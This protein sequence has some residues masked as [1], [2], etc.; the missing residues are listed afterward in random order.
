MVIKCLIQLLVLFSLAPTLAAATPETIFTQAREAYDKGDYPQAVS[1]YQSLV[2]QGTP[3]G[4]L[5]YNLGNSYYRTQAWG[6]AKA[7]Y[8]AARGLLPRNPDIKANLTLVHQKGGD[9]L[10]LTR[11]PSPFFFW[12]NW[13]TASEIAW[14]AA[15]LA[16]LSFLLCS[17]GTCVSR[18]KAVKKIGQGGLLLASLFAAATWKQAQ[19]REIWGAVVSKEAAVHS[20]PGAHNLSLFTLHEGAPLIWLQ[21]NGEW[22]QILLVEDK[23][24]RKGWVDASAIRVYP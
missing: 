1:L 7:A 6:E 3:S 4:Y 23:E 21:T 8:L 5:Y 24:E 2:K 14:I 18:L 16:G 13:A 19:S 22:A 12:K 15:L 10:Q 17:L 20:A 9:H 11:S